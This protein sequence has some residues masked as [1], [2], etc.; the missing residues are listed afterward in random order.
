MQFGATLRAFE[1]GD[2][3]G[4]NNGPNHRITAGGGTSN[5]ENYAD[6]HRVDDIRFQFSVKYDSVFAPSIPSATSSSSRSTIGG[7]YSRR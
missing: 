6:G 4:D 1:I 7:E 5:E 2:L 3:N